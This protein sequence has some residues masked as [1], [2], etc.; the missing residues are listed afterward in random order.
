MISSPAFKWA[1]SR[2]TSAAMPLAKST[3]ISPP[4]I[5]ASLSLDDPLAGIAVAAVLL[6]GLL[7]LDEVDDRLRVAEGVGAR[8]EDRVGDREARLLPGLAGVHG[9]RGRAEGGGG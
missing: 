3:A 2:P 6:A 5:A 8:R 1:I 4:S 7:L 9:R